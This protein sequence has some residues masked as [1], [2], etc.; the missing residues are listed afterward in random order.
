MTLAAYVRKGKQQAAVGDFDVYKF[1]GG[2]A[3]VIVYTNAGAPVDGTSG[4]LAAVAA[5]GQLLIDTTNGALYQNT[6]TLA[7]PTWTKLVATGAAATL[8]AITAT[9]IATTGLNTEGVENA[10]TASTTQTRVGG[11][12]LT[13][14]LNRVTTVANA[15]DAVTLPALAAG[16]SVVVFNDGANPASVFPNGASDAIDG[17]SAG[18][19]VTLTNAKRAVFVCVAANTIVSA[20]LGVPAA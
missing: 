9:S 13:E 3:A 15:G 14:A 19:A 10:I 6:N 12:A 17:G 4:T 7:S 16:Q 2:R 18:A 20:Q 8:G 5:K 11:T 1:G